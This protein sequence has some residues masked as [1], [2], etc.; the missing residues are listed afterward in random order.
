MEEI[1]ILR[2][3][4]E[5]DSHVEIKFEYNKI[6]EAYKYH[7]II[8]ELSTLS[9]LPLKISKIL[10]KYSTEVISSTVVITASPEKLI[11]CSKTSKLHELINQKRKLSA[12]YVPLPGDSSNEAT[13]NTSFDDISMLPSPSYCTS[14]CSPPSCGFSPNISL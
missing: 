8:S 11:S 3:I 6:K 10:S 14:P 2:E 7:F 4:L 12:Y 5:L 9:V 13:L 1:E